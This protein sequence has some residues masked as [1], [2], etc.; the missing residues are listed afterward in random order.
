MATWLRHIKLQFGGT[1][2]TPA[3]EEWSNTLRFKMNPAPFDTD[4]TAQ[5]Q[6]MTGPELED[7]LE[8]IEPILAGWFRSGAVRIN[9]VAQLRWAKLNMINEAGK[10]WDQNTHLREWAPVVGGS[11]FQSVPW[12]QTQALTMRTEKQRGRAHSGRIFPPCVDA[13]PQGLTP[14]VDPTV[15]QGMAAQFAGLLSNISQALADTALAPNVDVRPVI[16]S[17]ATS[18]GPNPGPALLQAVVGVVVDRIPDVQHRRT[19][20]IPRLES[21]L[22]PVTVA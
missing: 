5:S 7:A 20:R 18:S 4:P 6:I 17:P 15:A 9:Q 12:Y 16:A 19:N 1:L 22:A 3:V 10:Q 8:A 21:N 11:T 14:Y 2:G 13:N